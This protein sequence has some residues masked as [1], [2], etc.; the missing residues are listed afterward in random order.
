MMGYFNSFETVPEYSRRNTTQQ[1]CPSDT[2]DAYSTKKQDVPWH[3][4]TYGIDDFNYKFNAVGFRCDNFNNNTKNKILFSGCSFTEGTGLPLEHTWSYQLN[5]MLLGKNA[6]YF[7]I[8]SGGDSRVGQLRK[9]MILVNSGFVPDLI[10]INL[11]DRYR[12]EILYINEFNTKMVFK[13]L[14]AAT[15]NNAITEKLFNTWNERPLSFIEKSDEHVLLTLDMFCK[16]KKIPYFVTAWNHGACN[17][18]NSFYHDYGIENVFLN[19]HMFLDKD[20]LDLPEELRPFKQTVAR[21]YLHFGPNSHYK[22]AKDIFNLKGTE[23][24]EILN[25]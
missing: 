13:Y 24:L 6:P 17:L 12:D 5:E 11:P 20:C 16:S 7:S 2:Y 18:L 21:D 14:T 3:K 8:A 22:L 19:L 9:L 25:K 1:W 10:I 4:C 15:F 23:F